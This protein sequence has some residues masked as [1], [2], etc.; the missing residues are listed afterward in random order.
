M[1]MLGARI[2]QKRKE[3]GLSLEELGDKLGVSRQCVSK[4]ENSGVKN[5]DRDHIAKMAQIFHVSPSWLM[6]FESSDAVTV[7]YEA[8][9]REPVKAIASQAPIIGAASLRAKLYDVAINV[10]PENLQT[11][12]NILKSL[13]D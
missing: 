12:I 4:W 1:Q 2:H 9:G 6:G 11:A 7:T 8:P 3:M 13:S 10:K 5:I